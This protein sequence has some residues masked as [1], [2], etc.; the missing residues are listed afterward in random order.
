M[1]IKS[2]DVFQVDLPYIGGVYRLSGGRT[3][4]S[5]DGTVVRVTADNGLEGWGEST[6][7]GSTY[8]A[9]HA[10]GVRSG[11]DEMA[12]GLIGLDPRRVDRVNDAMDAALA[13]HFHAKA[14]IDI[15]CWDLFGKSVELPVC[16]LLGGRTDLR[17]PLISSIHAGD[18]TDVRKRVDDHRN[19]G[20]RGHS[21]KIGSDPMS[22]AACI[23]AA[24]ADRHPEEFFIMDA[25]GGMTVEAA[26]RMLRL[27]PTGLDFVL[28]APCAT[29]RE[30][31]SLRR[32]TDIPIFWD[33]LAASEAD[34]A[35]IIA[36]DAADGIGLKVTKSGGLTRARRQRDMCIA[37]GYPV[38]VQDTTG[39]DIAFAAIVHLAQTVPEKWLRCALD[40]RGITNR[41]TAAGNYDVTDGTVTAPAEP[42]LGITPLADVLGSPV[43][44]YGS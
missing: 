25:N 20:Y 22:N 12:P 15:A 13:G 29:W 34:L 41:K 16:E 6:P 3:Y 7:F 19:Q 8:I 23:E 43:A 35:W 36:Q 11:I 24:L 26:L 4:H 39:S 40:C 18:P 2:I 33:E 1:K 14:P 31:V 21:V 27:L 44:H 17:L 37:A 9:A 32:R 5:F 42:G 38:S 10:R 30:C 28:E